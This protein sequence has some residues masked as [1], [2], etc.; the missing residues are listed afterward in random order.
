MTE[1]SLCKKSYFG[2]YLRYRLGRMKGFLIC[3]IILNFAV[4]PLQGIAMII[5]VNR[6]YNINIGGNADNMNYTVMM[7]I[8]A[9]GVMATLIG[10]VFTMTAATSSYAFFCKKE[11]TDTLGGLPLTYNQR[12]WGDFLG[13]LIPT[14]GTFIPSAIVGIILAA[15]SQSKLDTFTIDGVNVDIMPF[16]TGITLTLFFTYLFI[17]LLTTLAAM[18]CGRISSMIVFAAVSFAAIP[19]LVISVAKLITLDAP[20][21]DDSLVETAQQLC[22][23]AGLF[24]G[25]APKAVGLMFDENSR[26]LLAELSKLNFAVIKP[27]SAVVLSVLAI[28]VLVLAYFAGKG[29]KTEN[30]GRMFA[31]TG[32]FH[33]IVILL[34]AGGFFITA[35]MTRNYHSK[36]TFPIGIGVAAVITVIFEVIRRPRARQLLK[37]AACFFVTA[38]C[39]IG[40]TLILNATGSFGLINIPK[41][42]QSVTIRFTDGE[43]TLTDRTEINEFLDVHNKS[44]LKYSNFLERP[45]DNYFNS[46][47]VVAYTTVNGEEKNRAYLGEYT[48]LQNNVT[49]L[50]FYSE[51][52]A[53]TLDDKVTGVSAS[54]SDIFTLVNVPDDKLA[55]FVKVFQNDMQTHFDNNAESIGKIYVRHGEK[56][57]TY[58]LQKSYADTAR[59]IREYNSAGKDPDAQVLDIYFTEYETESLVGGGTRYDTVYSMNMVIHER[60]LDNPKVKELLSLIKCG[61]KPQNENKDR[62]GVTSVDVYCSN[63]LSY[64]I[65][66]ED[67]KRAASLGAE[68]A[69]EL[70]E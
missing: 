64:H 47:F 53:Q 67:A 70:V 37:S 43:M 17:Y 66:S 32:Y 31:R 52:S 4:L 12:F 2:A 18:C 13:G 7:Y 24:L 3:G 68:I 61:E 30:T 44:V 8:L 15:A 6:M 65:P 28:A 27:I 20:G 41:N 25:D 45:R 69:L 33:A 51:R 49:A 14:V 57:N 9:A 55:E 23:P 26:E 34:S 59:L 5:R 39:C 56:S 62:S 40:I 54:V 42:V 58:E 21:L 38:A 22:M 16:F 48:R 63:S 29:R 36:L 11:T 35:C 10:V 1:P 50:S 46:G 19:V 60:D